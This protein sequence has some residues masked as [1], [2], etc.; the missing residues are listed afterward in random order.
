MWFLEMLSYRKPEFLSRS[1]RETTDLRH[2]LEPSPL[3]TGTTKIAK[4]HQGS[5][6]KLEESYHSPWDNT[7]LPTQL[8]L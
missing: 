3:Y 8:T 5:A 4:F 2:L 6:T 1:F 7:L